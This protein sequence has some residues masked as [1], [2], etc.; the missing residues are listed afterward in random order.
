M[1][2][3]NEPAAASEAAIMDTAG[4]DAAIE[5][6]APASGSEPIGPAATAESVR[7]ADPVAQAE[8]VEIEY[9][10]EVEEQ[11]EPAAATAADA[12]T[13]SDATG[14]LGTSMLTR[15]LKENPEL[16]Q[17][18]EANPR[19]KAQLYQMAR[20]SQELAQYQELVPSLGRA[21]AAV[22]AQQSLESYDKAYFG[23]DPQQ[24]WRGL[25]EAG[26]ASGAYERNV[27]FLHKV[28]LDRM[29]QQ[30]LREGSEEL[31]QAVQSIRET[32]GWGNSRNA[33]SQAEGG[34]QRAAV[35]ETNLPPQIRQRLEQA[36]R[37]AR[38][39]EQLRTR[40]SD[41]ERQQHERFLD[42]TTQQVGRDLRAFVEGLLAPAKL[43]DY[44]KQNITRDFIESAARIANQDKVHNA[45]LEE[46]LRAGGNTPATRQKL[47]ARSLA[48]ARQNGRDILEPILQRAG[49]GLKQRQAQREAIRSRARTEPAAAGAPAAPTQLSARDL[50]KQAEG[51]LGRRLNDREILEL[52]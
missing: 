6:A 10:E 8:A 50:I 27:Q 49:A 7:A 4:A 32:L 38:E 14:R 36:D 3:A 39:L 30:A 31:G 45:A 5:T 35:E 25:Y 18:V 29:E 16:A 42:E 48:W 2:Q 9:P 22:E 13:E 20:R 19:V 37:E 23:D 51:R 17:A 44:D 1:D 28:F 47:A 43:S 11:E 40:R 26:R 41:E 46:I 15:T 21:R 52:A 24:F 33:R 12:A 34:R